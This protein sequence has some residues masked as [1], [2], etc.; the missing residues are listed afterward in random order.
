MGTLSALM[1]TILFAGGLYLMMRKDLYE[2]LLGIMLLSNGVNLFMLSMGGWSREQLPPILDAEQTLPASQYADPL[3]QAFIL[4][5]IVIS[6]GVTA[7]IVVLVA[8]SWEESQTMDA[9]ERG[10]EEGEP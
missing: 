7:V 1:V 6:F 8:R 4:T 10:R 5:A 9:A 2:V 3:V